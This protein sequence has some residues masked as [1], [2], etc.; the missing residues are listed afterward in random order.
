[1][2]NKEKTNNLHEK[3][4]NLI[5]EN[6]TIKEKVNILILANNEL[7]EGFN[8]LEKKYNSEKIEKTE[9]RD[10]IKMSIKC[11]YNVLHKK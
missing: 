10:T 11:L 8:N 1:M 6:N 9:L 5:Q 3:V 4:D 7:K 2:V